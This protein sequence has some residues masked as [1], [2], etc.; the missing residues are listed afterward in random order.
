MHVT[1]IVILALTIVI[2]G[3][4]HMTFQYCYKIL[5]VISQT[6][7]KQFSRIFHLIFNFVCQHTFAY[8]G[9]S[10]VN[11]AICIFILFLQYAAT[12]VT[13]MDKPNNV[14]MP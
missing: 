6:D 8:I 12:V 5:L 2:A 7:V 11:G 4:C 10:N 1:Y 13:T 3:F 9:L 14:M